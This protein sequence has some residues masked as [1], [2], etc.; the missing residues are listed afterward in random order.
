MWH[1]S[2]VPIELCLWHHLEIPVVDTTDVSSDVD[3]VLDDCFIVITETV[4]FDSSSEV[5]KTYVSPA[6]MQRTVLNAISESRF[7]TTGLL[8]PQPTTMRSYESNKGSLMSRQWRWT[9]RDEVGNNAEAVSMANVALNM[10]RESRS[11]AEYRVMAQW[12]QNNNEER[13]LRVATIEVKGLQKSVEVQDE[14]GVSC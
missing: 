2:S 10:T 1:C 12:G 9:P 6:S 14:E 7:V 5:A 13:K 11:V 4:S 3:R 8:M